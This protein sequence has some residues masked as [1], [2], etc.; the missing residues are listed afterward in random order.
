MLKAIFYYEDLAKLKVD[1]VFLNTVNYITI[2]DVNENK[3]VI[4]VKFA[5]TELPKFSYIK[6]FSRNAKVEIIE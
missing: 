4:T 5:E 2:V 1:E 6:Y 3:L